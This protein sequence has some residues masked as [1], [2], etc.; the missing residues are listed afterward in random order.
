[1]VLALG[2]SEVV[3]EM[4]ELSSSEGSTGPGVCLP[5]GSPPQLLAEGLSCHINTSVE[6]QRMSSHSDG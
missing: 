2:V 6:V 5:H 1:M 4:L 3:V